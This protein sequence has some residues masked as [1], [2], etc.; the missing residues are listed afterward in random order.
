MFVLSHFGYLFYWYTQYVVGL[1]FVD[2]EE[3]TV[4]EEF[5]AIGHWQWVMGVLY[6]CRV[7]VI[8]TTER[9]VVGMV[10]SIEATIFAPSTKHN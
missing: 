6:R 10:G 1:A 5:V 9:V 4:T 3:L 2:D 7:L 8:D